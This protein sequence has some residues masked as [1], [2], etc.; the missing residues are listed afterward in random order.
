[1]NKPPSN[2]NISKVTKQNTDYQ[3]ERL[4]LTCKTK[5]GDDGKVLKFLVLKLL[6]LA[7]TSETL[8]F[9]AI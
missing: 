8:G 5:V 1:M 4:S 2:T 6:V 3:K 9:L 7:K